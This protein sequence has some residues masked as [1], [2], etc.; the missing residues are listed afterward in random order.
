MVVSFRQ[1]RYGEHVR[2]RGRTMRSFAFALLPLSLIAI[3]PE[4]KPEA[5]NDSWSSA[6]RNK[7][8]LLLAHASPRALPW[9][10]ESQAFSLKTTSPRSFST[11][12][13]VSTSVEALIREVDLGNSKNG[14]HTL[15]VFL[16]VTFVPWW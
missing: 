13:H 11:S 7:S 14:W 9:A 5:T 2:S 12:P 8:R 4:V 16:G 6:N 15:F 10:K 3:Q 1:H